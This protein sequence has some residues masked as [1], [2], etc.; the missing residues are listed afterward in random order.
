MKTV[1]LAGGGATRLAKFIGTYNKHFI[2]LGK[3]LVIEKAI[4]DL[5]SAGATE[6]YLITNSGWEEDF[7]TFL[8][9]KL[10]L[11][12]SC[13]TVVPSKAPFIPL[14]DVLLQAKDFI[15]QDSFILYLGDNLFMNSPVP[16]I[17]SLINQRPPNTIV[18]ALSN[19]PSHFGVAT[20][21]HKDSRNLINRIEEKPKAEG[22]H[23]VVT[24]LA[25]YTP[26]VFDVAR[27]LIQ[28][29]NQKRSL[30]DIHNVLIKE[31]KLHFETWLGLWYDV[32]TYKRY[33]K[34]LD[35]IWIANGQLQF[36]LNLCP[37]PELLKGTLLAEMINQYTWETAREKF[38]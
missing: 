30:S 22:F 33:F 10:K 36:D 4:R 8:Q 31:R 37:R 14:P 35:G 18:L 27:L 7:L 13:V 19:E 3:T 34:S 15:G 1:V 38:K 12:R 9:E 29:R 21:N 5:V 28:S 11:R 23:W 17:K 6:F 20:F 32:G 16:L 2:P 25:K 24:G 26:E